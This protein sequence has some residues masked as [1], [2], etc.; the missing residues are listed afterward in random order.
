MAEWRPVN[1]ATI[2]EEKVE[3]EE[4]GEDGTVETIIPS[5]GAKADG[6][7]RPSSSSDHDDIGRR[8]SL[9]R[10]SS[11]VEKDV[12]EGEEDAQ[13]IISSVLSSITFDNEQPS[14]TVAAPS[15]AATIPARTTLPRSHPAARRSSSPLRTTLP[16]AGSRTSGFTMNLSEKFVTELSFYDPWGSDAPLQ[17]AVILLGVF[18]AT[19]QVMGDHSIYKVSPVS[20]LAALKIKPQDR[21]LKINGVSLAGWSHACVVDFVK[22]LTLSAA[23]ASTI[24][25]N[26]NN[27]TNANTTNAADTPTD[28][29]LSM[30]LRRVGRSVRSPQEAPPSRILDATLRIKRKRATVTAVQQREACVRHRSTLPRRIGVAHKALHLSTCLAESGVAGLEVRVGDQTEEGQFLFHSFDVSNTT[31]TPPSSSTHHRGR[32]CRGGDVGVGSG[33]DG[34]GGGGDVVVVETAEPRAWFLNATSSSSVALMYAA[35]VEV[36]TLMQEDVRFFCLVPEPAEEH[37][38]RLQNIATGAFLSVALGSVGL[39]TRG[40]DGTLP[41]STRLHVP[42]C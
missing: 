40:A 14:T 23:A 13:R 38:Y 12:E 18:L 32:D 15:P 33:G 17:S 42:P 29:T 35:A 10:P 7:R 1:I 36:E 16:R 4:V 27:S 34:G 41:D 24:T 22:S 31:S 6:R 37:V 25:T 9:E 20:P 19:D 2:T 21:L 3:G 28:L 11:L 39:V 5:E 30:E 8:P 26:T